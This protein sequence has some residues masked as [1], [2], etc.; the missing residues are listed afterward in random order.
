MTPTIVGYIGLAVSVAVIVWL[1][2]KLNRIDRLERAQ[3]DWDRR[4][5]RPQ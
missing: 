3:R 1:V 5:G 2:V 4:H